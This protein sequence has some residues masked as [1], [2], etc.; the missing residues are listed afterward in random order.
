MLYELLT[1]QKP[2][3]ARD[4]REYGRWIGTKQMPAPPSALRA[5]LATWPQ[6]DTLAA[7]LLQFDRTKRADAAPD[8]VK[9]LTQ[10]LRR[11]EGGDQHRPQSRASAEALSQGPSKSRPAQP[12]PDTPQRSYHGPVDR[13]RTLT[14][15]GRRLRRHRSAMM[16]GLPWLEPSK[17]ATPLP[18]HCLSGLQNLGMRSHPGSCCPRCLG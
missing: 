10:V 8:V 16:F 18:T 11:V 7:S 12:E 15:D 17:C 2:T 5:E 6:L 13:R 1:G 9:T 3:A 4:I 14:V